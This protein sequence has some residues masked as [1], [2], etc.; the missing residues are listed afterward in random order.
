MQ[1]AGDWDEMMTPPPSQAVEYVAQAA[2]GEVSFAVGLMVDV[3]VLHALA[4]SASLVGGMAAGTVLRLALRR[5]TPGT[6]G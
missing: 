5:R 6:D 3:P 1:A 4:V 2:L